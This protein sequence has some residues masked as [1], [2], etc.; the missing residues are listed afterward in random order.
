[1]SERYAPQDHFVV[2]SN[3]FVT[4]RYDWGLVE[5]KIVLSLIAQLRKDDEE[6]D[7]QRVRMQDIAHVT[8]TA[9][10]N[11]YAAGPELAT[12]IASRTVEARNDEDE[13]HVYT[14]MSDCRY[15]KGEGVLLARFNP[16]MRPLL[17]QLKKRF[18]MY[19]LQFAMRLTSHYSIRLY[20][21]IKMREELRRF[22]VTV[23]DL[24][25]MLMVEDKYER[26]TDLKKHVIIPARDEIKKKCDVYFTFKVEREGRTPVRILFMIHPNTD[27]DRP[28]KK[29]LVGPERT[30]S[31]DLDDIAPAE[32][33]EDVSLDARALFLGSYGDDKLN[34]LSREDVDEI[35]AKASRIAREHNS[36][37]I[38]DNILAV[39]VYKVMNRIFKEE[40]A[41]RPDAV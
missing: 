13:F 22:K 40:Y 21:L 1:M 39:E 28:V 8:G 11:L 30:R 2:K 32:D 16:N 36:T 20:E 19:R 37:N 10:Q 23:D 15:L 35:Y 31:Q 9:P 29:E 14:L 34:R 4:A 7:Y 27:V 38:S 24:R 33:V 25:A 3:R 26:F 5:Q 12:K 18:T 6:F 17:M 41:R